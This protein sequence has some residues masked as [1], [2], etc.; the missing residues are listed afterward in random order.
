LEGFDKD[1]ERLLKSRK[2]STLTEEE[3]W[4]EMFRILFPNDEEDL[5]PSPCKYLHC[6]PHCSYTN[7]N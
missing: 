3:K 4:K 1:Q 5:I 7:T 6:S 2:K